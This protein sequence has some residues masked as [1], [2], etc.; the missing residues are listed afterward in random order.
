MKTYK[1]HVDYGEETNKFLYREILP[2]GR[3]AISENID[4]QAL[5]NEIK[6]LLSGEIYT[7]KA[8]AKLYKLVEK[9]IL[10][11]KTNYVL[12]PEGTSEADR[13]KFPNHLSEFTTQD[14]ESVARIWNYEA[15]PE[16]GSHS[17]RI[18]I[19]YPTPK[20]LAYRKSPEVLRQEKDLYALTKRL[21]FELQ[22]I[23]GQDSDGTYVST[24]DNDL[25][26]HTGKK[27]E[28]ARL[29]SDGSYY[30]LSSLYKNTAITVP[31]QR[32]NNEQSI[33]IGDKIIFFGKGEDEKIEYFYNVKGI[34]KTKEGIVYNQKTDAEGFHRGGEKGSTVPSEKLQKYCDIIA[35]TLREIELRETCKSSTWRD[36]CVLKK[37]VSGEVK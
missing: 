8:G 12:P 37:R 7:K 4:P 19:S 16:Y 5:R 3:E 30:H 23:E 20:F 31:P 2:K 24:M 6:K 15:H 34:V 1:L 28:I 11:E 27:G 13:V 14:G 17:Q 18:E 9:G 36:L 25:E 22:R 35:G 10:K 33:T 26:H 32:F 21:Q 29:N